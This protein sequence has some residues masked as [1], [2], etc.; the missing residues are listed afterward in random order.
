MIGFGALYLRH[1]RTDPR[2]K[3]SK[4]WDAALIIS[5]I[6]LLMAGVWGAV[7]QIQKALG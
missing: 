4:A 6:G 3:P 2:L 5:C 1:T 7:Q